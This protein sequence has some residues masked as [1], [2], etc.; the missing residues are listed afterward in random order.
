ME[1]E[2]NFSPYHYYLEAIKANEMPTLSLED[3]PPGLLRCLNSNNLGENQVS[4]VILLG[5]ITAIS[6][7]LDGVWGVYKDRIVFPNMFTIV[8]GQPGCGKGNLTLCRELVK[9]IHDDRIQ[10]SLKEIAAYKSAK[11]NKQALPLV[12]PRLTTLFLPANSSNVSIYQALRDNES[13]L[14]FETEADALSSMFRSGNLSDILRRAFHHEPITYE[15]NNCYIQI[16]KPRLSALLSGTPEQVANMMHHNVS[17]GLFSRFL[18]YN[19]GSDHDKVWSDVFSSSDTVLEDCFK[20]G[21]EMVKELYDKLTHQKGEHQV[22]LTEDQKKL[23]NNFFE[24]ASKDYIDCYGEKF[25][26]TVFRMG[27]NTFRII[28]VLTVLRNFEHGWIPS[29]LTCGKEDFNIA[30]QMAKVLLQHS[31]S[32]FDMMKQEEELYFKPVD[33]PIG[34]RE[35]VFSMLP[36]EFTT[37][38]A[39][40]AAEKVGLGK[41]SAEGYLTRWVK[42]AAV[43]RLSH[44]KYKK[45]E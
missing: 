38:D 10:E 34:K 45:I 1:Q 2:E 14:L 13:S 9:P 8:S 6:S 25:A 12:Q 4:D 15:R 3:T 11:A 32:V 35:V 23:F 16:D 37:Q 43:K 18:Y 26:A 39:I 40:E 5:T 19:M 36:V 20:N 41:K 17:N 28:M 42:D 7:I 27:L 44:S 29:E 22:L 21:G 24:T 30:L 31:A 33:S